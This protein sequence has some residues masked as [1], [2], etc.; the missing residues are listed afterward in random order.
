M[1]KISTNA[2]INSVR[3]KEQASNPDTPST[4]YTQIFVKDDGLYLKNDAGAVTGPFG[5]GT[6]SGDVVGP[7]G[8]TD[9]SV[10]LFD[11]VTG[12]LL[13]DGGALPTAGHTIADEGTPLTARATLN[14]VGDGVA[15]TDDAGNN[16]T[17]V[18][19]SGSTDSGHTILDEGTPLT[20]RA[21]LNFVGTGVEVT[22]DAGNDRTIVTISG[23][24]VASVT[25]QAVFTVSSG[26]A[27]NTGLLQITNEFGSTATF[28]RVSCRVPV[29]VDGDLTV[30]IHKD[31]TTIFTTQSN[32]PV[33][34][35]GA[36]YGFTTTF[37]VATWPDGEYLTM[38]VD[39]VG[40]ASDL[41]V[42]VA[43]TI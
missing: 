39:G 26:V 38:D 40:T 29:A 6:G 43:F 12:K 4:G 27:I 21:G 25:H 9:S 19:I 35:S 1:A 28:S 20:Q 42:V 14:F 13:K 41:V 36:V 32:R 5:T 33:I 2:E 16:R 8:A 34:A 17:V 7:A 23:A 30:D 37:D 15:V 18:T 11:G 3:L 24:T 10:A 31:G 22:D